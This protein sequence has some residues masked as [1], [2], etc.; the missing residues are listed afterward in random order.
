MV[1][2]FVRLDDPGAVGLRLWE[3]RA[4]VEQLC[5]RLVG[6][7]ERA[8]ELAQEALLIAFLK[9]DQFV[10]VSLR[11]W[12]LGI[13]RFLCRNDRRKHRERL[14]DDGSTLDD[15]RES[16]LDRLVRLER[17][18]RLAEAIARLS[19]QEQHALRLKYWEG[20]SDKDLVGILD[21]RQASGARG[22]LQTA[23]R[24]LRGE[25][26]AGQSPGPW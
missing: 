12:V 22:L 13:A 10:G 1:A 2:Q 3:H 14:G 20:R 24:R 9:R 8:E 18:T 26:E 21:L 7:A 25:L 6:S 15:E 19:R 16:P 23:R 5:R 17:G 11:S 4:P